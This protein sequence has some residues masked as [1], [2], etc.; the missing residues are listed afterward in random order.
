MRFSRISSASTLDSGYQPAPKQ[1]VVRTEFGVGHV[2]TEYEED[3]T[4]MREIR[5]VQGWPP[6]P[7]EVSKN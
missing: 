3:E 2:N 1:V 4:E 7:E 5:K 6:I